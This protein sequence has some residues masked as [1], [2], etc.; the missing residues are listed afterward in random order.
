MKR[1]VRKF[2]EQQLEEV[3]PADLL[4][5]DEAPVA[6]GGKGFVRNKETGELEKK[7]V[8]KVKPKAKRT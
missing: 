3:V 1:K 4:E 6:R 7:P 8:R 2:R 5:P